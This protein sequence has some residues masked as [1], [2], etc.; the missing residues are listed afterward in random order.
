MTVIHSSSIIGENVKLADDMGKMKSFD[1][2]GKDTIL[3]DCISKINQSIKEIF[4]F[5]ICSNISFQS[6]IS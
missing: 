3:N 1:N 2:I 5:L 6:L 4:E